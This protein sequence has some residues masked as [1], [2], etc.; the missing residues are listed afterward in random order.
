M[1]KI[2]W[3]ES[4]HIIK[5]MITTFIVC[6][7]ASDISHA[8]ICSSRKLFRRLWILPFSI[9]WKFPCWFPKFVVRIQPLNVNLNNS[10]KCA[11]WWAYIDIILLSRVQSTRIYCYVCEFYGVFFWCVVLFFHSIEIL[12]KEISLIFLNGTIELWLIL[13]L[14]IKF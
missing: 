8:S 9:A 4:T 14:S 7:H 13:D 12:L 3:N 11:T 5:V 6:L 2:K 10:T 1:I